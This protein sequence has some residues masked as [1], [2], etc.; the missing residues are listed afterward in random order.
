MLRALVSLF[1]VLG[2]TMAQAQQPR[3]IVG[4]W[5]WPDQPC[6]RGGGAIRIQ[7]MEMLSED[8]ACKFASVKREGSTVIWQGS[9]DSAEGGSKQTVTATEV[10]NRL[11]I[12]FRPGGNTL[13]GLVRC[14]KPPARY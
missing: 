13:E 9:C 7:P 11:T 12:T 1:L 5:R 4:F 8:V 6:T 14:E 2:T 10:N 3:T